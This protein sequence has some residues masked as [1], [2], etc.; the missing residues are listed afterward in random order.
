MR[1][2][3]RG[4]CMV[5]LSAWTAVSFVHAQTVD[6]AGMADRA[7]TDPE[8]ARLVLDD[9]ENFIRVQGLLAESTDS[10]AVLQTEYLDKGTPGLKMFIEKYDF[11]A[12]RLLNAI[13][14]HPEKY[15]SL[16]DMP[17][18]I[19]AYEPEMRQAFI[20]LKE[21]VPQ[22]V[23]LPTYFL[24]GAYRGIGSG[25]IEGPLIT[26]E[27][28]SL[29]IEGEITMLIHETVHIQ[30]VVAVGYEK[31]VA[32]FGPEKSLLGLCIREG[33]AEFIADLVTG[34]MTQ[35]GAIDFIRANEARLWEQFQGEMHGAE[36]GDW[37]WSTPKD[38]L[39]PPHVG[40][41]LGA[42]ICQAYYD[43]AEDKA[44]AVQDILG[45]TDYA[46]FLEASGYANKF[47]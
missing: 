23:F 35:D 8:K 20:K 25:S 14:K 19:R 5:V 15:S 22:A 18:G 11:T 4:L 1:Y 41:V 46:A 28:W 44:Q 40:Y 26:V 42:L 37:M 17:A 21:V 2:V 33:T 16:Q 7:A 32:L 12:E 13:R 9:V 47:D 39:Q 45:V 43:K 24:V 29:P 34:S 31:Y 30:Q 3:L 38:S 27:K 36:T 6:L 10:F